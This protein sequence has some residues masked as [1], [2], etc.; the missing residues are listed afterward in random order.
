MLLCTLPYTPTHPLTQSYRNAPF[1]RTWSSLTPI[2]T[3]ITIHALNNAAFPHIWLR[4]SCQSSPDCIHPSNKQK[5]HSTS[6]ILLDARPMS[7][8]SDGI[9]VTDRE[10]EIT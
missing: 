7:L 3:G 8:D 6:D 2:P 5:L 4:D 9:R 1:K 10:L